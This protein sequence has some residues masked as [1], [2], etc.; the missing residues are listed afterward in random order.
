M[1]GRSWQVGCGAWLISLSMSSLAAADL[2]AV[3]W[4]TDEL[5][6]IDQD[7]GQ[8]EYVYYL[9][10]PAAYMTGIDYGPD[11]FLY[12]VGIDAYDQGP[13]L[14]RV[15][16]EGQAFEQI[17]VQENDFRM[18]EGDISFDPSSGLL[19]LISPY[20]KNVRLAT[21][22]VHSGEFAEIGSFES[23]VDYSSLAFDGRGRLW[24]FDQINRDLVEIDKSTGEVLSTRGIDART[25]GPKGGMDWDDA[26][27][28]M[29][30]VS[31]GAWN[32]GELYTL[33]VDSGEMRDIGFTQRDGFAGLAVIPVP[34]PA[35]GAASALLAIGGLRRRR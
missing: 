11:N 10:Y 21:I 25:K 22:D 3:T 27:G 19:Y 33:D 31:G 18:T 32:D 30:F 5:F 34:A 24:A 8:A 4:N 6:R 12:A 13:S 17:E 26:T 29:Y 20:Y 23:S 2:L 35:T 16:I 9:G 28:L 14:F 1:F 7:T 15:D